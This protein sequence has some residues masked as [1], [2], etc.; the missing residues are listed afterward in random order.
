MKDVMD[1]LNS[2]CMDKKILGCGIPLNSAFGKVDYC[3]IGS[4]VAL[5]WEDKKLKG[6]NYRERISTICAIKDS[7]FRRFLN[8]RGFLND[9]DV[10]LLRDEN[11]YL[12][13][14]QKYTLFLLNLIFGGL[15]FTSDN[16]NNYDEEKLFLYKSQFPFKKKENINVSYQNDIYTIEFN[17]ENIK[18]TVYSNL[19]ENRHSLKLEKNYFFNGEIIEKDSIL[20]VNPYETISL[21][22]IN[23]KEFQIIGSTGSIFAGSEVD[24]F[25]VENDNIII[26]I[27]KNLMNPTTIFIKIPSH[28]SG[29]KIN[30][31]FR[32]SE[33]INGYKIIK[34]SLENN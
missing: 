17:I 33:D 5:I 22:D 28:L 13:K 4:D 16:L 34:Y 27:N 15:V 2:L 7:I 3:R 18:Y 24:K 9:P 19:G 6:I 21:V 25:L 14:E 1:F 32:E 26:E 20:I 12:N 31:E 29:Y 23:D 10:F 8:F 30:N 11:I